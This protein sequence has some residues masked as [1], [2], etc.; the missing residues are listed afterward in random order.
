LASESNRSIGVVY[1]V[2]AGPGD[3]RLITL[4]GAE[5][6]RTADV[7]VFDSLANARLL[8]LAPPHAERVPVGK[9]HGEGCLTQEAI[10][11]MLVSGAREGKI[12][13]RLKGGDPFVFGRGG[14]EATALRAAGVRYE[15]VPGVTAGVAV[16][17]YAGIPV[18]HRDFASAVA[19]VTGHE[20][21]DKPESNLDWP[22]LAVFPG[23]LVFYMGV[24]RL[25]SLSE[26]LIRHGKPSTTA[27]AVIEW[28][29]SPAQRT[30]TG[31]L[32]D[33]A[34]RVQSAGLCAPAVIVIGP[35]ASLAESLRWFEYQP[36]F[37]Q[38]VVI[39]R[40]THQSA[41]LVDRLASL[42]AEVLE[43]PAVRIEP[44]ADWIA[45]DRAIDRLSD[46]GWLVFTSANGVSFFMDRLAA[47]GRDARAI[48]PARIAAIGSATA[49]E[50][51]RFHLRAD[52]I[53]DASNSES[54]V[55]AFRGQGT[56]TRLLLLRADRGREAL[57]EGLWAARIPFDEIAVYRSVDET[58]WD[59]AIVDR[60]AHGEVDWI[61]LT[62]PQ[63]VRSLVTHLPKLARA[64]LGKRTKLASISAL[65]SATAAEYGLA[66]AAE[67]R[68]ASSE[69]L[70]EA[71]LDCSTKPACK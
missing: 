36:L 52:L 30:V 46:F 54:L 44:P 25:A 55:E 32:N 64:Q 37:G 67:A 68:T 13:V 38:R 20:D 48:G 71:I 58:T 42:G 41:Q 61:T 2:G 47:L 70:I 65:T 6:L 1:L 24:S 51:Q 10:N 19:F 16:P 29:T 4:R 60:I 28:G 3:P 62:S 27:A 57:P 15:V 66:V 14:E 35:V 49:R 23:T 9:R 43:L 8:D 11:A 21:P 39:T 34:A 53:P 63:I 17:A 40:P 69:A 26:S 50:L 56:G 31:M 59:S 7:V 33:L 12:V 22:G 5:C 45:V 18:T